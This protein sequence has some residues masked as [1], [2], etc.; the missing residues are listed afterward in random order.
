MKEFISPV[1]HNVTGTGCLSSVSRDNNSNL[2]RCGEIVPPMVLITVDGE[3][4]GYP[5]STQCLKD[6]L[7]LFEY[8]GPTVVVGDEA[9]QTIHRGP[10][11]IS[12]TPTVKSPIRGKK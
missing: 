2:I 6:F 12:I 10:Y 8:M 1:E 7:G 9:T 5:V 3:P 4:Q 11:G